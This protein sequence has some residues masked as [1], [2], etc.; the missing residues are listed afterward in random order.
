[1][2]NTLIRLTICFFLLNSSF[3]NAAVYYFR[4]GAGTAAQIT[5]LSNWSPNA[6]GGLGTAP[7]SFTNSGDEWDLNV[8]TATAGN[9]DFSG[10]IINGLVT[11][12][13][14][15][16]K[17]AVVVTTTGTF[18]NQ[19][20][21]SWISVGGNLVVAGTGINVTYPTAGTSIPGLT[22][23]NL[24]LSHTTGT[25]TA[26]G[27]ITV[28]GT[29]TTTAGGTLAMG[30]NTLTLNAGSTLTN[31]GTISTTAT[32]GWVTDSRTS[33]SGTYNG[34]VEFAVT[35]GS[36]AIS[37]GTYTNLTLS[38]AGT[39]TLG[40]T[41]TVTGILTTA[42]G[43]LTI[44][45]SG[46]LSLTGTL[47]GNGCHNIGGSIE[48]DGGDFFV[49]GQKDQGT[50]VPPFMKISAPITD[51]SNPQRVACIKF[52]PTNSG[53]NPN[54][55]TIR[56]VIRF[57]GTGITLGNATSSSTFDRSILLNQ[58]AYLEI[59]D[60]S[61]TTGVT[62]NDTMTIFNGIRLRSSS[63]V[64]SNNKLKVGSCAVRKY[65][66]SFFTGYIDTVD[67][68]GT[69]P[70]FSGNVTLI[71]TVE[72]SRKFRFL[73]NPFTST[74]NIT[75]F[76]DD[77][78]ITGSI[79]TN[80]NNFTT[81]QFNNPSAFI[82]NTT[83]P[84]WTAVTSSSPTSLSSL[85]GLRVLV[86][87]SKGEGLTVGAGSYTPTIAR[88]QISG[89]PHLGNK[90]ISN[91][92]YDAN[93]FSKNFHFITNPFLAPIDLSKLSN[94]LTNINTIVTVY[95][96]SS[97]GYKTYDI[98]TGTYSVTG[99]TKGDIW[100]PGTSIFFETTASNNSI[101]I[102]DLDKTEP[103]VKS[104]A[105]FFS[106]LDSFKNIGNLTVSSAIGRESLA[107]GV[108]LDFGN[109]KEAKD[110]YDVG[111][112]GVDFGSDSVNLSLITPEG[113]YLA[114]SKTNGLTDNEI[115][116]YPLLVTT[117][118]SSLNGDYN[119]T[120]EQFKSFEAGYQVI[121]LDKLLNVST[122]LLTMPKYDF[123]ISDDVNSKGDNRFEII[124][125]KS[126]LGLTDIVNEKTID[127][128][129]YQDGNEGT[130]RITTIGNSPNQELIIFDVQGKQLYKNSSYNVIIPS[131]KFKPGVYFACV[132]SGEIRKTKKFIIT[133]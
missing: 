52:A 113:K 2:K 118:N 38:G 51:I 131:E 95:V 82:Y 124:V 8:S 123:K 62:F 4:G 29:L 11:N 92:S 61:T 102:E 132:K 33:G 106:E 108:A 35:T 41:V 45:T 112:D 76:T 71:E 116:R 67:A 15:G 81:T 99:S 133:N 22:Y 23:A 30:S 21:L 74:L 6:T 79:G 54:L 58:R 98:S 73:G 44:N 57:V 85:E 104:Y 80:D 110:G 90:T 1:M 37:T 89:T 65:G 87:G 94:G 115:R 121:L 70:S 86:R 48:C 10:W 46:L 114:I 78:D 55:K 9:F 26:A 109:R 63:T 40:S 100:L 56:S 34:Q 49:T 5:S 24:T 97:S 88:I 17:N 18:T 77:I 68:S 59:G 105:S 53:G 16:A 64:T 84:S 66:G 32:S 25:S 60:G 36:Q 107:D 125:A 69:L 128:I 122:D 27:A 93:A 117:R 120:F 101:S 7:T 75:D 72:A 50:G 19:Y 28:S 14:G 47:S 83:G 3:S 130:I 96:P 129:V 119:F 12:A 43:K 39:K 111:I 103:N 127:C 126:Q 13:T 91:L 31:N 42:G 20:Q